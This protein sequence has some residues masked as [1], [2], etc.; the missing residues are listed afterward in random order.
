MNRKSSEIFNDLINS[1][2]DVIDNMDDRW[3][4]HKNGQ[5]RKEQEFDERLQIS[6]VT[7]KNMLDEYIDRRIETFCI[8]NGIRRIKFAEDKFPNE[9]Y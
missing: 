3:E 2:E 9:D 4:A 6:K 1:L 7:F 8:Q 5:W